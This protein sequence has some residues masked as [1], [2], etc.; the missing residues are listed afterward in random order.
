VAA[1]HEALATFERGARFA[2]RPEVE[3]RECPI[4]V[5]ARELLAAGSSATWRIKSGPRW[6]IPGTVDV[7]YPER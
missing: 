1:L 2:F 5:S 4:R 7:K 6:A 3:P